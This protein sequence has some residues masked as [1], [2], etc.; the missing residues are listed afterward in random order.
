MNTILVTAL[1]LLAL[2]LSALATTQIPDEIE[3]DGMS[4]PV[5]ADPLYSQV[6]QFPG[7]GRFQVEGQTR[8]S[9][10]WRGYKAFWRVA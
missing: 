3:L 1:F 9:A 2:P 5:Q 6:S 8:Y 7:D 10:N 4:S